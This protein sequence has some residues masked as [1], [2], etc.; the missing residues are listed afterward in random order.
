MRHRMTGDRADD[1]PDENQPSSQGVMQA[2][3]ASPLS[4]F[5][6]IS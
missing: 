3:P 2:D 4:P 5:L 6:P 1:L